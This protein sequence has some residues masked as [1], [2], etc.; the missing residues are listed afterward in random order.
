MSDLSQF[1][2]TR[3]WPAQHPDRIP[4]YSTACRCQSPLQ[5]IRRKATSLAFPTPRLAHRPR[6]RSTALVMQQM[7]CLGP[8]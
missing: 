1:P 5:V 8:G 2:I 4:L 7:R 3:R 6:R